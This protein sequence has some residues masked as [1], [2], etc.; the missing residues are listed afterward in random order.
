VCYSRLFIPTS[1]VLNGEN[2]MDF[3][4]SDDAAIDIKDNDGGFDG[5]TPADT[6]IS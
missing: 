5:F 2:D 3:A 1:D 4:A 6:D